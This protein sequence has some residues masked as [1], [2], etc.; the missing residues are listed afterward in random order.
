M[1]HQFRS[2]T[3]F[4][5]GCAV[6][7]DTPGSPPPSGR[8][9]PAK[10]PEIVVLY[11]HD[12]I[13][14]LMRAAIVV[15]LRKL[16]YTVHCDRDLDFKTALSFKEWIA[17][18]IEVNF[19]ICI[20]SPDFIEAF[21]AFGPSSK[22]R[23]VRFER[24]YI[25][26]KISRHTHDG[27]RPFLLV[28]PPHI[29][30]DD[31]SFTLTIPSIVR[32]Q[33]GKDADVTEI[34]Q[35]IEYYRDSVHGTASPDEHEPSSVVL[36]PD[37]DPGITSQQRQRDVR[38]VIRDLWVVAPAEPQAIA[39]VEELVDFAAQ[40]GRSAEIAYAFPVAERIARL[41]NDHQLMED[42]V[43]AC[44]GALGTSTLRGRDALFVANML[45]SGLAWAYTQRGDIAKALA[46]TQ[47]G[48]DLAT[49]TPGGQLLVARGTR[50]LG[51]LHRTMA[52]RAAT[53]TIRSH[54]RKSKQAANAGYR[55]LR[56]LRQPADEVGQALHV[57]A[58]VYYTDFQLRRSWISLWRAGRLAHRTSKN[59][60]HASENERLARLLLRAEVAATC[61]N[62]QLALTLIDQVNDLVERRKNERDGGPGADI[63][64]RRRLV[65]AELLY[66]EGSGSTIRIA[67]DA[68]AA[69]KTFEENNM[70]LRAAA[71]NWLLTKVDHQA[72]HLTDCDIR[73]VESLTH[74]PIERVLAVEENARRRQEYTK[75]R[76]RRTAEWRDILRSVRRH[77][78]NQSSSDTAG[79]GDGGEPSI[80]S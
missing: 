57:R 61:G 58:L 74:N 9:P 68:E 63:N 73:I 41:A 52:E 27:P 10:K 17:Y 22:R 67:E 56:Q 72:Q 1:G 76:K 66:G 53:P 24:H 3:H 36:R 26:E 30:V 40:A 23:G 28:A 55:A 35:H 49:R 46:T 6:V 16:G 4:P 29:P 32:F 21:G 65:R 69:Q 11:A 51:Y 78:R 44:E 43:N 42:L 14:N 34:E 13:G 18:H 15:A 59:F 64:A 12:V 20:L 62:K 50:A 5:L 75:R 47:R 71:A 45:I 77:R 39:F 54:L 25:V 80:G 37:D 31:L 79:S 8:Q 7:I 2:T 70:P 19:V 60:P 48:V 38:D 33:P